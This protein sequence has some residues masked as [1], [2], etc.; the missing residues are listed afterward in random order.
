M[1]LGE[2][3]GE[4]GIGVADAG[5]AWRVVVAA[6]GDEAETMGADL[7]QRPHDHPEAAVVRSRVVEHIAEPHHEIRLGG[8]RS[9]DR[10]LEGDLEI[11]LALVDAFRRGRGGGRAAEV[12]VAQGCDAH[13]CSMA[14]AYD[15]GD[16]ARA[17][18]SRLATGRVAAEA[19]P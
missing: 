10:G 3:V 2:G 12:G 5:E 4:D 9:V 18:P 1:E 19:D 17:G 16:P 11:E 15:R 8:Q 6:D 14:S 13:S 7:G